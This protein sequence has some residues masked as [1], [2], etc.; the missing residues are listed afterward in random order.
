MTKIVGSILLSISIIL[1]IVLLIIDITASWHYENDYLNYWQLADKASTIA[2]KSEYI[3]K[4]VSALEKSGL[5]G[6]N[7]NLIWQTRNSSFNYNF[8]ALKSLQQR[9]EDIKTMDINSFAYQTAIQQIT[10]QEQGEAEDM[11]NVFRSCWQRVHYPYLWNLWGF[12]VFSGV[13]LI[14]IVGLNL[15]VF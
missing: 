11:L 6:T 9:L 13:I 14:G 1:G 3:D 4:F 2:Q 15:L 8:E 7:A 12:L 5:Q 10:A